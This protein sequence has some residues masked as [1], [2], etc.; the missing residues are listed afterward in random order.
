MLKQTPIQN[1]SYKN[2]ISVY[3]EKK[4]IGVVKYLRT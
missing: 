2:F 4:L 3:T 1:R